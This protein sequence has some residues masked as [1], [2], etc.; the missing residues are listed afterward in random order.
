MECASIE[1]RISVVP[2]DSAVCV[3]ACVNMCTPSVV[4]SDIY[5]LI[6]YFEFVCMLA[7][8]NVYTQYTCLIISV[9]IIE[10]WVWGGVGVK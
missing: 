4:N 6:V 10:W 8:C 5:S 2:V 9:T 1:Y 7:V 3:C